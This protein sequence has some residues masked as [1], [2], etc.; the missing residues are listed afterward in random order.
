MAKGH[1]SKPFIYFGYVG[2]LAMTA[3]KGSRFWSCQ[4]GFYISGGK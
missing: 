2:K 4:E 3:V 1:C